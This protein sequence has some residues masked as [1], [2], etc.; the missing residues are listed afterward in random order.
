MK[1][2]EYSQAAAT[3]DAKTTEQKDAEFR[4][5]LKERTDKGDRLAI[6]LKPWE[7]FHL[8]FLLRLALRDRE[9]RGLWKCTELAADIRGRIETWLSETP[10]VAEHVNEAREW[11]R[12]Y[13]P[14]FSARDEFSEPVLYRDEVTA[15]SEKKR[16]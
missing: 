4:Q 5:E 15:N 2:N 14:A 16:G 1:L 12:K 8:G 3:A 10:A 7:A 11:A 13:E 6:E 9:I